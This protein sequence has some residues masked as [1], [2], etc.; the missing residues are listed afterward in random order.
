[1]LLLLVQNKGKAVTTSEIIRE[2]WG[3]GEQA[4]SRALW[5]LISRL[6]KKLKN[7][8]AR[9]EISSQRGDGYF[10]ERI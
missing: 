6:R 8:N 5:T 4:N 9:L 10:L 3:V 2:I 1:M 7:E